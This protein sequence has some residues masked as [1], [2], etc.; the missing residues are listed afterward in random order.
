MTCLADVNF[1]IA[2]TVDE[3]VHHAAAAEWLENSAGDRVAF[4]RITQNGFLRLLTNPS[5]M[6]RDVLTS[7]GAW[8]AYDT[9]STNPQIRFVEEPEGLEQS[10]RN[11]TRRFSKGPN[12]W[13]DA[14]LA[15]FADA[16]GFSLVTFDR[17]LARHAGRRAHLLAVS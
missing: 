11:L 5:V 6:K 4:C 8:A 16:A 3:H 7:A 17:D 14:Y 2:L 10:W 13:T 15:A 9:L 1:W 12:F